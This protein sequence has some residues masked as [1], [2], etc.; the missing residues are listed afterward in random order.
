VRLKIADDPS[1]HCLVINGVRM[2]YEFLEQMTNPAEDRWFRYA[3]KG[4]EI[5]VTMSFDPGVKR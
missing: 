4:D 3:R 5:H 1:N 2:T